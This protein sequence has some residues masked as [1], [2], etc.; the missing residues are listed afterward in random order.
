MAVGGGHSLPIARTHLRR[1][2]EKTSAWRQ[3]E[4]V[5]LVANGCPAFT[6]KCEL[7]QQKRARHQSNG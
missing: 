2:F 1:L 5:G 3:A 6:T 7:R 4:L